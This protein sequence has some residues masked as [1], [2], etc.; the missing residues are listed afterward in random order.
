MRKLRLSPE[1]LKVQSFTVTAPS[2]AR[3][4]VRA[5]DA[6]EN[7]QPTDYPVY[8]CGVSCIDMCIHTLEYLSCHCD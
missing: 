5:H 8:T 2:P 3:G 6:S 4:T 7:C 1:S